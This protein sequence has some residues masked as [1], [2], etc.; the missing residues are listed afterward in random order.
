MST[1]DE[2]NATDAGAG[3]AQVRAVG[4]DAADRRGGWIPD[5]DARM[6]APTTR[7]IPPRGW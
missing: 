4:I 3:S 1:T 6:A 5:I 2:T 7:S